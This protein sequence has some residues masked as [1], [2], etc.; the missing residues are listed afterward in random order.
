MFVLGV[1]RRTLSIEDEKGEQLCDD[2]VWAGQNMNDY[3]I[4]AVVMRASSRA[5]I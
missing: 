2:D 4:K 5:T 3:K 1:D